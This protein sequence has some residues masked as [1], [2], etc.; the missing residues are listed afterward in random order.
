LLTGTQPHGLVRMSMCVCKYVRVCAYA[1][2]HVALY[3]FGAYIP[4]AWNAQAVQGKGEESDDRG[5]RLLFPTR[6]T[7]LSSPQFSHQIW[8][9]P[10][11]LPNRNRLL[12]NTR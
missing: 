3:A 4:R 7:D 11:F 5:S 12:L 8:I 10:S 2:V 6:P 9:S 1:C